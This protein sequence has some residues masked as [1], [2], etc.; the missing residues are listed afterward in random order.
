MKKIYKKIGKC[1][2]ERIKLK[3]WEESEIK[4]K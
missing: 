1:E 4:Y 2:K 3:S